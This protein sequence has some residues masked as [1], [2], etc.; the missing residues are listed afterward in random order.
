MELLFENLVQGIIRDGY[1]VLDGFLEE[2][3]W[4][5]LGDLLLTRW[6]A[7]EFKEASIGKG[8][9]AIRETAVRNDQI[10]WLD[11]NDDHP[12]ES[13]YLDKVTD[14][15][16]YLNRTCFTNLRDFEFHYAIYPEGSFYRRHLDQFLRDDARKFSVICYL[17]KEWT[18]DQ[19]GQLILYLPD[20][21]MEILPLGGRLVCFESH[22]I[23]HEVKASTRPRMSI[24]GW[25]RN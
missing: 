6:K 18:A 20:Q 16:S 23:E 19:G 10:R 4:S 3:H 5:G 13:E 8:T 24:T 12:L 1:V 9:Q 14:L 2:D 22:R 17:N 7:G 11:R 15:V 25:L 21:A